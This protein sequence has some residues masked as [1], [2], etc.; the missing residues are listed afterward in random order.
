[1]S[2]AWVLPG[3][4]LLV[5]LLVWVEYR[6]SLREGAREQALRHAMG[7]GTAYATT[8]LVGYFT[9]LA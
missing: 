1:M 4:G 2:D 6:S 5:L 3:F 9:L 8:N 7:W